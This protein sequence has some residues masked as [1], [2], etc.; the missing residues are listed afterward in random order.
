MSATRLYG[1]LWRWHFVAGV[2]AFPILFVIAITGALYS[3]QPEL[4]RWA[5]PG[6]LTVEPGAAR[7]PLDELW[8]TAATVCTPTA[9][10]LPG[11]EDRPVVAYCAEGTRR[12]VYL[13]P[14]RGALLGER[15]EASSFFGVIFGLHWDLL[16]GD[17]GRIAIE[18]VTSWALLLLISG[19][20]LWW[21]RGKRRGGGVWWPRRAVSGR[22]RLRDLHAVIGAYALP[23]LLVLVATGLMW[24]LLAGER[25][26][27]P[28]TEDTVHEAWDDRPRSTVIAGARPIG[29]E[30]ALDGAGL[31]PLREPRAIYL[32]PPATADASYSFLLYDDEHERPS[33]A[34][35]I[36]VD[37][38]S[39]R[40]LL[41]YG[42]DDRSVIGKLDSAHYGLHVGSL[43]GLPGRIVAC[44]A[45]LLLAALCV[46]G[47][48]MW[49][50]RRPRGEFGVPPAA[51]RPPWALF[52]VLAGLG[53]L[54]P[55][56]GLTLLA[57]V[58][59]EGVAWLWRARGATASPPPTA[60]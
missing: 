38:Y 5:N 37:A 40:K 45:A 42:W 30:A 36:W 49:W 20:M 8:A 39:G 59:L 10:N 23:V 31:D 44:L 28:L 21:P 2:A 56:I 15:G 47:P 16:L 55:A 22:Q 12:E 26:W 54:L 11:R 7:R 50:K 52:A 41:E 33:I 53:W 9:V 24:T 18:W 14:Y 46:T 27:H 1:I 32:E 19:A 34:A 43:L 6:L 13:D 29:L 35:S 60:G 57:V 17:P 3:F 4:D 48:W 51:R 25:R 58:A